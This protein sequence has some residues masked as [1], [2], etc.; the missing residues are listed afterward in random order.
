MQVEII[1]FPATLVAAV[2]HRG[3][4]ERVEVGDVLAD[5]V[6]QLHVGAGRPGGRPVAPGGLSCNPGSSHSGAATDSN[7]TAD[8]PGQFPYH[9][10]SVAT[11]NSHDAPHPLPIFWQS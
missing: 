5:E 4:E 2:E 9:R 1:D 8:N 11:R 10:A 7:A 6:H 3:P